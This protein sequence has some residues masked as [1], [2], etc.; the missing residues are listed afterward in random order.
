MLESSRH[1][2]TR[3][4]AGV[5]E[6][7]SEALTTS[8]DSRD[9]SSRRREKECVCCSAEVRRGELVGM[10]VERECRQCLRVEGGRGCR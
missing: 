6:R 8:G 9:T 1:S 3:S 4:L 5:N 10:M 7:L 2:E